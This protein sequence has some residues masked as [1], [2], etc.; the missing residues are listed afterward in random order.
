MLN[1]EKSAANTPDAIH[2]SVLCPDRFH[3]LGICVVDNL[4]HTENDFHSNLADQ[5]RRNG[6]GQVPLS[7]KIAVVILSVSEGSRM[8]TLVVLFTGFF[9]SYTPQNDRRFEKVRPMQGMQGRDPAA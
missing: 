6:I 5:F 3:D 7:G 8:V 1:V 9:A 4:E 2:S